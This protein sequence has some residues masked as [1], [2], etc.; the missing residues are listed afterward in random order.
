MHRA[1]TLLRAVTDAGGIVDEVFMG[2]WTS[3]PLLPLR[4]MLQNGRIRKIAA[5]YDCIYAGNTV[6][7]AVTGLARR[8]MRTPTIF[9]LHTYGPTE[10][11][12][13]WLNQRT[14]RNW[15]RYRTIRVAARAAERFNDLYT[16]VSTPGR[17]VLR[18]RGVPPDRIT[19]IRNGVDLEAFE[20]SPLPP[21]PTSFGYA[22]SMAV[23]Q[24]VPIL[25]GAFERLLGRRAD[26]RCSL[27]LYGFTDSAEDTAFRESL[28]S[29]FGSQLR[30]HELMPHREL[31]QNLRCH[32][33][34]VITSHPM[35]TRYKPDAF[36]TKFAE[37]LALGR[38]I[39]TTRA[40]ESA[41]LT[42]QRECGLVCE[43]DP[44]D[45]LRALERAADTPRNQLEQMAE[46]GLSLVRE[47]F[48]YKVIRGRFLKV[49]EH[50]VK[51]G[52]AA[53]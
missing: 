15:V 49:V 16:V 37:Y 36:P 23:W 27:H 29:H 25:T 10:Q 34:L 22:G 50:A 42:E 11:Y 52:S 51:L 35:A 9:D 45:M 38:P 48:D 47:E 39:I 33:W 18:S 24:Q 2:D 41:E 44:N 17:T 14:K 40:Y 1:R 21:D 7:A 12:L 19:L 13:I 31:I 32:H 30:T 20:A 53:K 8:R 43:P 6:A 28:D 46:R 5:Q 4:F 3:G 26:T